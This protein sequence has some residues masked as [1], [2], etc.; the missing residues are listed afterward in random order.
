VSWLDNGFVSLKSF[1][2]V[3]AL[4]ASSG[5][6]V[7]RAVGRRES[8]RNS[9]PELLHRLCAGREKGREI[10]RTKCPMAN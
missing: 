8:G 5:K 1:L 10:G 4:V 6:Q 9:K 3:T 2:Q 7:N